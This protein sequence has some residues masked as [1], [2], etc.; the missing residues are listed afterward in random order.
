MRTR[1]RT[2]PARLSTGGSARPGRHARQS[3][4]VGGVAPRAEHTHARMHRSG[5]GRPAGRRLAGTAR[6]S[7]PARPAAVST[8]ARPASNGGPGSVKMG[9]PR[10][11][12]AAALS[13]SWLSVSP[14]AQPGGATAARPAARLGEPCTVPPRH[15][16]SGAPTAAPLSGRRS[17]RAPGKSGPGLAGTSPVHP[18]VQDPITKEAR[19]GTPHSP[20]RTRSFK[21]A[22]AAGS[23][24][25]NTARAWQAS[26]PRPVR[27]AA[28]QAGRDGPEKGRTA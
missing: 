3:K 4:A 17:Q 11:P 23:D 1:G 7:S 9:R 2:A 5:P 24:G 18:T 21:V 28:Q 15:S 25:R 14:E 10:T 19:G 22:G 27:W 8:R 26:R 16:P 20:G 12:R 13:G 6:L